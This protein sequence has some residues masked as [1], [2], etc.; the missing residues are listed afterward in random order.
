MSLPEFDILQFPESLAGFSKL[1]AQDRYRILSGSK[2][3]ALRLKNLCEGLP[4]G[5]EFNPLGVEGNPRVLLIGAYE[6]A[7]LPAGRFNAPS[8][9][10]QRM[11]SFLNAGGVGADIFSVST[12]GKNKLIEHLKNNNYDF[13]G[14]SILGPTLPNDIQ[15]M[16]DTRRIQPNSVLVVG[17][18]A[19]TARPDLLVNSAADYLI[20]G[21]GED[22]MLHLVIKHIAGD[23]EIE[24]AGLFSR[25]RETKGWIGKPAQPPTY[26]DIRLYSFLLNPTIGMD[27]DYL[28][29]S[30]LYTRVS[31]N[32]TKVFRFMGQGFCPRD[33]S[34]CSTR[35]FLKLASQQDSVPY[36]SLT[37]EDR[38]LVIDNILNKLPDLRTV[39]I[40]DD[41]FFTN[42]QTA[43]DFFSRVI[44]AKKESKIKD[45]KFIMSSRIDELDSETLRLAKE[46]GVI[47]INIGV[48]S[49]SEITLH[50]LSKGVNTGGLSVS[51]FINN[52]LDKVLEA[53]IIPS[54]NLI[55]F[56]P[57]VD[58]SQI[59]ETAINVVFALE[60]GVEINLTSYIRNYYG[61]EILKD[62]SIDSSNYSEVIVDDVGGL[63]TRLYK[64][65]LLPKDRKMQEFARRVIVRRSKLEEQIKR[66][67]SWSQRRAP[68]NIVQ[69][70]FLEA[71]FEEAKVDNPMDLNALNNNID[72]LRT[73]MSQEI[74]KLSTE[75]KEESNPNYPVLSLAL[76]H[77][78][79]TLSLVS[80]LQ[81]S[82]IEESTIKL[83]FDLKTEL[84]CNL[85]EDE[86]FAYLEPHLK[87]L[88]F[89]EEKTRF[90]HLDT[91][92]RVILVRG[93]LK[94]ISGLSKAQEAIIT[95]VLYNM[96]K[97]DLSEEEVLKQLNEIKRTEIWVGGDYQM[98]ISQGVKNLLNEV[99]A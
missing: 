52:S 12:L 21:Y 31:E 26:K 98:E 72:R 34:F 30:G 70:I 10:L 24:Y 15:L 57:Y 16:Y 61:A 38:F 35:N 87:Y 75:R 27:V 32:R 59:Y 80:Q 97:G 44:S 50:H 65:V 86:R 51:K 64:T 14:F 25:D 91:V 94:H 33:C 54:I 96:K 58:W 60:R 19:P 2:D 11:A 69:M 5:F 39:F 56:H 23:K 93:L 88:F 1:S 78:T 53:G 92:D 47:V 67:Y 73:M 85:F 6:P 8:Y 46:A 3:P 71:L 17:G 29:P 74:A 20:T 37:S 63:D 41:D 49:F 40:S 48:E 83:I 4:P 76:E 36:F 42:R 55:I 89:A 84:F 95:N 22:P 9:G 79:E 77:Q 13:I 90:F 45:V 43:R 82:G 68:Q 66:E 99:F 18:P 81:E 28:N 62:N 7:D